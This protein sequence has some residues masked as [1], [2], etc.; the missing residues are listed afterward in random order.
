MALTYESLQAA[1]IDLDSA[2]PSARQDAGKHSDV[3]HERATLEEEKRSI[4][5]K[6]HELL[7]QE[8]QRIENQSCS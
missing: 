8:T 1:K 3:E 5:R 2:F 4:K 7:Q 6:K